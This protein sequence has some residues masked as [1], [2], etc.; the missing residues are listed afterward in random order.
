[1]TR[2][3][4]GVA[5]WVRRVDLGKTRPP[6]R[7]PDSDS[8]KIQ[9]ARLLLPLLFILP[10]GIASSAGSK[11]PGGPE[12][13]E[14]AWSDEFDYPD[15][16]LDER[17][18]SQN[19]P[20]GHILC[21]RW[22]E[23]A[24]VADGTLRLI[25]RKEKRGGQEWTSGSIT[26]KRHFQYGYFECRYRYAAAD[27]HEQFLLADDRGPEPEPASASRSTSTRATTRTRST[28][29]STTGPTSPW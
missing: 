1:M 2:S 25:N 11:L 4:Q 19:G 14:L 22:R 27:G 13:W 16:R 18:E 8:M 6:T 28:P 20:S 5:K 23:N 10:V 12:R 29:T 24:V 15:Q 7:V 21:S 26:S 17:W 9:P 3:V